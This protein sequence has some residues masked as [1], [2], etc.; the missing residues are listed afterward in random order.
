VFEEGVSGDP[1]AAGVK[2]V[3]WTDFSRERP[4][5]KDRAG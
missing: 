2:S 1:G 5:R 4:I 3:Q